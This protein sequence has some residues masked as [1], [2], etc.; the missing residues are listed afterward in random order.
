MDDKA[1]TVILTPLDDVKAKAVKK[2][3]KEMES[4]LA[5]MEEEHVVVIKKEITTEVSGEARSLRLRI[6]KVRIDGEKWKTKEKS[7]YNTAGKVIQ[8]LYN[9]LRD[10][11]TKME[12]TLKKIEDHFAL[13]AQAKIDIVKAERLLL[14]EPYNV[15]SSFVDLGNMP[16]DAWKTHLAG[17]VAAD[18]KKKA[19]IIKNSDAQKKKDARQLI[20]DERKELLL[21]YAQFTPFFD[22]YHETTE[23]EFQEL[24]TLMKT[25]MQ[26]FNDSQ[27]SLIEENVKL[28]EENKVLVEKT[29][30]SET[31]TFKKDVLFGFTKGT[32]IS[33]KDN[34][35]T[36]KD[37]SLEEMLGFDP[38][39]LSEHRY[40]DPD[41]PFES[42]PA[43]EMMREGIVVPPK[44]IL[45]TLS[46]TNF[47][48]VIG[49]SIRE[50]PDEP[51]NRYN[52]RP[53]EKKTDKEIL[54]GCAFSLEKYMKEVECEIG[55][56]A[57]LQSINTLRGAAMIIR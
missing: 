1:L 37:A 50:D 22:L 11:T 44:E 10:K 34:L 53:A 3:Y 16:E 36:D 9:K 27:T 17:I 38:P 26:E 46:L 2:A 23:E 19:D 39:P 12:E 15:D 6:Q 49:R 14:L 42:I 57:M 56:N 18:E 52:S 5:V 31:N 20:F 33:K 24:F 47:K 43:S 45:P 30:S 32:P 7:Q 51:V 40:V 25:K 54:T 13:A 41:I 28:K 8:T 21:P 48:Q 35:A 55:R 29:E 4:G